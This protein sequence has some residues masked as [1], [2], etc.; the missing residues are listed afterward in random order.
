MTPLACYRDICAAFVRSGS[1]YECDLS[2]AFAG[3]TT[4]DYQITLQ[5]L[6]P[7]EF[8]STAGVSNITYADGVISFTITD[9]EEFAGDGSLSFDVGGTLHHIVLVRI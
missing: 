6:Q 1:S 5:G 7:T 9:A 4:G 2:E 8:Y 3:Y